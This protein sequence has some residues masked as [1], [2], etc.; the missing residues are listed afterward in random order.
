MWYFTS[1]RAERTSGLKNV[2]RQ[3]KRTFSA[4]SAPNGQTTPAMNV[5]FRS[6][7]EVTISELAKYPEEVIRGHCMHNG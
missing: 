1:A 4:L 7:A 2:V 5:S 6:R 3:L